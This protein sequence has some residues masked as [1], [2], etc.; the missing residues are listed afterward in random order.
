M[1][2]FLRCFGISV[3]VFFISPCGHFLGSIGYRAI[4]FLGLFNLCFSSAAV[5]SHLV[6]FCLFGCITAWRFISLVLAIITFVSCEGLLYRYW[7][8]S[9]SL[10]KVLVCNHIT[11]G[12]LRHSILLPNS[13][14]S[15]DSPPTTLTKESIPYYPPGNPSGTKTSSL[16][17]QTSRHFLLSP[18]LFVP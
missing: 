11:F 6:L 1:V 10:K 8:S 3:G 9:L 16:R 5:F 17:H 13:Q 7:I 15:R 18:P 12:R 4:S 2:S 14:A